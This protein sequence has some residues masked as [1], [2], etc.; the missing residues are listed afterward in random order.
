MFLIKYLFKLLSF[1]IARNSATAIYRIIER[2]PKI[3]SLSERGMKPISLD[4]N[5]YF[6]NIC[7]SYPSRKVVPVLKDLSF[8]VNL[9]CVKVHPWL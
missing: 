7:F 3:D 4:D 8:E 5:I 2:R 6:R 9:I 1:V